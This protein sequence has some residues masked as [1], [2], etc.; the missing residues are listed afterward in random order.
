SYPK[1][2]EVILQ[3]S[4]SDV[5][6]DFFKDK[7]QIILKLKSGDHL[8][9]RNNRL[10]VKYNDKLIPV[11]Q[12]SSKCND[13]VKSLIASG[14]EPYDSVVRFICA[15]KGKEDENES[16]VILADIFFRLRDSG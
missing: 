10:Y 1:P 7:K 5:Y 2:F 8:Y 9:V 6:L 3:L 11:L 14:Y 13:K 15:W 4:H 12:L 16:A